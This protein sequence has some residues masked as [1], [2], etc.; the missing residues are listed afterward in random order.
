MHTN[1]QRPE[2]HSR[3]LWQ[4]LLSHFHKERRLEQANPKCLAREAMKHA[5]YK[6]I[7]L[8]FSFLLPNSSR[9]KTIAYMPATCKQKP[10]CYSERSH[11]DRYCR[12][13]IILFDSRCVQNPEC[14]MSSKAGLSYLLS[15]SVLLVYLY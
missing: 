11:N 12:N 6:C 7:L 10:R 1:K 4:R 3:R 2:R 15:I 14:L 13:D 8:C 9:C 5:E